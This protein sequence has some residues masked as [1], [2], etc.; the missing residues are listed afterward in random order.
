MSL[1]LSAF[2]SLSLCLCLCISLSLPLPLSPSGLLPCVQCACGHTQPSCPSDPAGHSPSCSTWDPSSQAPGRGSP[3]PTLGRQVACWQ[4]RR[5]APGGLGLPQLKRLRR[6]CELSQN[7]TDIQTL[8][9][10]SKEVPNFVCFHLSTPNASRLP[11]F[12][13]ELLLYRVVLCGSVAARSQLAGDGPCL[14]ECRGTAWPS[15]WGE[16]QLQFCRWGH[17]PCGAPGRDAGRCCVL[18]QFAFGVF[19]VPILGNKGL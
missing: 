8:T 15:E 3:V 19:F 6:A 4:G 7:L 16:L 5:E 13:W 12:C 1:S 2:V 9:S 18:C 14:P 11:Q 10:L 17:G